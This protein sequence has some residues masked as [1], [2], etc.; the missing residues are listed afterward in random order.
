MARF[1]DYIKWVRSNGYSA[2]TTEEALSYLKITKNAFNCGMYK[3]KKKGEVISPAKN[4]YVIIPPEYQSM[5]CIPPA[6][7]IPL[8]MKHWNLNYYVC[9]LSAAVYFGAS[10]QKP[11]VFQVMTNKQLKPFIFGKVKIEF[12]FK[13][14]LNDLPIQKQVV[15]TGYLTIASPELIAFDLL[16]YPRQSGGL[17]P[18]ATVLSEL[19]E[20][21]NPEK[22]MD[23]VKRAPEYA[24]VQRLGYIL[25]HIDS[26]DLEK[27]AK[28]INGLKRYI[29]S[30]TIKSTPLA[31]ELPSKGYI[32]DND[33]KIIEN[34]TIES[35][36]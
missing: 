20:F 33:W 27:Q 8:I 13:K 17:N 30:K 25:E 2:F 31:S 5:G 23:L 34:T 29:L 26:M 16:N 4:L 24:W 9:L 6:E 28:I 19:I 11:Q 7:L 10:H 15:K 1:S 18:T 3:L 22:L 32:R 12:I 21:L 35:D 14:S 36:L